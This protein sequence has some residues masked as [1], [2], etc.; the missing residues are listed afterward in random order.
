MEKSDIMER[1]HQAETG[2]A[3]SLLSDYL[4]AN[5]REALYSIVEEEIS[6]LCGPSHRP[7]EVTAYYRSGSASSEIYLNGER[8]S[9]KRPRIRKR[10]GE[11]NISDD[12]GSRI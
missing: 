3:A 9:A 5:V 11:R 2:E 7:K 1:L 8:T 6:G 12:I 10:T 4:R